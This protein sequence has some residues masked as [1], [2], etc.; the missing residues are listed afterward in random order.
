[1]KIVQVNTV[2][3]AGS[4]GRIVA[5]LHRAS[6]AVGHDSYVAF[7]R[8]SVEPSPRLH[9]VGGAV[10]T[11]V[12]GLQTR[13]L[14]R[15]GLA[16]TGPTLDLVRWLADLRPDVVH[17]HNLHGYYLDYRTLLAGLRRDAV[18]TVW[19]LHD[20]WAYTGHCAYY[21][22]VG[23]D[24]WRAGCGSCP[25]LR[26]YPASLLRDRSR[27]NHRDKVDAV[28]G[29]DVVVVT[30]SRWLAEEVSGSLLAPFARRVVPNDPDT[31]V[32]RP[33][34]RAWRRTAGLREEDFVALA[35]AAEWIPRK[36]LQHLVRLAGLLRPDERLVVVGDLPAGAERLP[37][38]VLHVPRTESVDQLAE[39]YSASDVFLNPTLEDNYPTTNLEALA[40]GT[41]LITFPTGGSPE[42]LERGPGLVTLDRTAEA[43]REALDRWRDR[44]SP[45]LTGSQP[46]LRPVGRGMIAQYLDL[47]AERGASRGA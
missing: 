45:G 25:Q 32:F 47:Y 34:G 21:D 1:M 3:G 10:S 28:D 29:Q 11:A 42:A 17:L 37:S 20:C 18:P 7:G 6:L 2:Y 39:V 8:G 41:P 5:D 9:R 4:T 15:H 27:R 46:L 23:C 31:T 30:P 43:L 38:H 13:L 12:H 44:P 26:E 33:R 22:F 14:D 36:G 16:S 40:C 35:V 24:R 19:T